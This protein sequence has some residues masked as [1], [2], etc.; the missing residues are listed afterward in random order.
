M[1]DVLR[2]CFKTRSANRYQ[3]WQP[4]L[5]EMVPSLGAELSREPALYDE[6]W[7]WGTRVLQLEAVS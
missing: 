3:S 4:T 1:L 2:R 7:S 5:N 6:V